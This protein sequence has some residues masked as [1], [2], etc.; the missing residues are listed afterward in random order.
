MP[1]VVLGFIDTSVYELT[2]PALHSSRAPLRPKTILNYATYCFRTISRR[3]RTSHAEEEAETSADKAALPLILN[4]SSQPPYGTMDRNASLHAS[5]KFCRSNSAESSLHSTR[6]NTYGRRNIAQSTSQTCSTVSAEGGIIG[7]PAVIAPCLGQGLR[8]SYHEDYAHIID[9][10]TVELRQLK[11]E[12]RSQKA[13]G[14]R[15][16]R[17]MQLFEIN[18]NNLSTSKKRKLE[19]TLS[20]FASSLDNSSTSQLK[21]YRRRVNGLSCSS[22]ERLLLSYKSGSRPVDSAY[23]SMPADHN[24]STVS[25]NRISCIEGIYSVKQKVEKYLDNI[26]VDLYQS[27][28]VIPDKGRS[29][30]IDDGELTFS[31]NVKQKRQQTYRHSD[32]SKTLDKKPEL[33]PQSPD[34]LKRFYYKPLFIHQDSL[35]GPAVLDESNLSLLGS[36]DDG[37]LGET[38]YA[39]PKKKTSRS[40]WPLA[41]DTAHDVQSMTIPLAHL[42]CGQ[43]L[44]R[45]Y[46]SELDSPLSRAPLVESQVITEVVKDSLLVPEDNAAEPDETG[47]QFSWTDE[48]SQYLMYQPL[49]PCGLGNV[50]PDDHFTIDVTTSRTKTDADWACPKTEQDRR[51]KATF[52]TPLPAFRLVPQRS[53]NSFSGAVKIEYTGPNCFDTSDGY[54]DFAEPEETHLSSMWSGALTD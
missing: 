51:T 8:N 36:E 32:N 46:A 48:Q 2:G 42:P 21:M 18:I 24:S 52:L 16:L 23:A 11:K 1:I 7:Q 28:G 22:P 34:P 20:G 53:W 35:N 38:K 13:Q 40:E 30:G 5:A 10:L 26:P 47:F 54:T 33:K 25:P 14:P 6:R 4:S 29:V 41:K 27:Q 12:L 50:L 9:D 3:V 15:S 39:P 31:R 49:E 44:T 19:A 45:F 17:N 37:S 43:S